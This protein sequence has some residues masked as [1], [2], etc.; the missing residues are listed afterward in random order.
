MR[1]IAMRNPVVRDAA[2][3]MQAAFKT[4]DE[5]QM[6]SAW[7]AFHDAVCEAVK[8][9][10]ELA[11]GDAMVLANRGYR[12]LTANEKKFYEKFVEAA[13]SS[14]PKQAITD[15]VNTDGGMPQ[16]IIEDV[17]KELVQEHSLLSEI[18]F[19]SASYLTKWLISDHT[20]QKAAWGE[21]NSEVSKELTSS[22]KVMDLALNKLSCFA[23][24]PKDMLELG[25][26]FLDNYIRT[27]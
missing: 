18:S 9:D 26:K 23:V 6:T 5:A 10:F 11:N 2:Q 20:K 27:S 14:N 13:K 7:E 17:Y 24:I 4:G 21:I 15:L 12:Q 1:P 19:T 8:D 25:P 22:F 3:K 16:T